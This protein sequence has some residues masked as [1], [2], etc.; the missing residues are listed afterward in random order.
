MSSKFATFLQR[1]ETIPS[2]AGTKIYKW[3][4]INS[5]GE[6]VEEERDIDAMI[7]SFAQSVDYKEAIKQY[8][9]DSELFRQSGNGIYADVT[10][11]D[12]MDYADVNGYISNLIK[13]LNNA[14]AVKNEKEARVLN[15]EGAKVTEEGA[16]VNKETSETTGGKEE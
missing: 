1:R 10:S 5:K 7:Q 12:Q 11:F 15:E 4:Y 6:L 13:E 16:K 8:G 3:S 9:L 2:P 14:L